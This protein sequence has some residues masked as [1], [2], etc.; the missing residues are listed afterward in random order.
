M[1]NYPNDLPSSLKETFYRDYIKKNISELQ[2][3]Q[4]MPV[5]ELKTNKF[6][7]SFLIKQYKNDILRNFEP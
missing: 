4:S 5:S 2:M 1:M 3:L 6:G 7:K